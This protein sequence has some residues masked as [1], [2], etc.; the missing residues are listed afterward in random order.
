MNNVGFIGLGNIGSMMAL[1]LI[2]EGYDVQLFDLDKE[3]IDF[4]ANNG[5]KAAQ[6]II[7]LVK[8]S[9][10][11]LTSLPNSNSVK[12]VYLGENGLIVNA[13][14]NTCFIEL[15]TIDHETM[16]L[17]ANKAEEKGLKI[18]DAPVSGGPPEAKAGKLTLLVG[19]NESVFKEYEFILKSLAT[20]VF[21]VGEVGTGK[22][23]KLVNNMITLGNIMVA[24]EAFKLGVGGGLNPERLYNVLTKC[25]GRS[26]QFEKRIPKL[27][28]EDF[29]PGFSI[30]LATK[31]LNLVLDMANAFDKQLPLLSH[32]Y[33]YYQTA[34]MLG[35]G[36]KD[37]I[38]IGKVVE[39]I[40]SKK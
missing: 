10:I 7:S 14:Q 18:I 11:V 20:N 34:R 23:V 16:R 27:I 21:L 35:Y 5:G 40:I 25:A 17:I 32:I 4:L 26:Y 33:Q 19:A 9:N 24:A 39:Q 36:D 38:A 37:V 22:I 2:N 6:D 31:D 15:S 1:R 3:K 29:A 8:N 30:D 13:N 12:K 28:N